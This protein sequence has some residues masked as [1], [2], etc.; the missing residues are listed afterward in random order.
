MSLLFPGGLHYAICLYCLPDTFE[1]VLLFPR[2]PYGWHLQSR[3]DNTFFILYFCPRPTATVCSD[4]EDVAEYLL[5]RLHLSRQP[6]D[7]H[8][9]LCYWSALPREVPLC[10]IPLLERLATIQLG[11]PFVRDVSHSCERILR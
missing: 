5:L 8:P 10:G 1:P 9:L 4:M 7:L 2:L 11:E 6:N 3:A